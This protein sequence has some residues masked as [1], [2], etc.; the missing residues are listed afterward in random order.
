[1]SG[2]AEVDDHLKPARSLYL[3][4]RSLGLEVRVEDDPGGE[5]MDYRI[6][7]GG[8]GHL[9]EIQA[10]QM[11][12]RILDNEVGLAQV[13]LNRRDPDLHAIRAEGFLA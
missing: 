13:I 12:R 6:A 8:F 10:R 1:M 9:S 5:L 2:H 3:E 7:I 11:K 4:L